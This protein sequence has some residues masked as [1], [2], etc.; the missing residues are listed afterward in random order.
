MVVI[1]HSKQGTPA[2]PLSPPM[3]V[4]GRDIAFKR[5]KT[6]AVKREGSRMSS[7]SDAASRMVAGKPARLSEGPREWGRA[8]GVVGAAWG[9][10][11]R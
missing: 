7:S 4:S 3:E 8:G 5:N 11:R 2:L 1:E 10:T 9:A 6:L